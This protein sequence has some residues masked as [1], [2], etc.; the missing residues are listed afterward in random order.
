MFTTILST[1]LFCALFLA[2][3][4]LILNKK[5]KSKVR[6]WVTRKYRKYY[7]KDSE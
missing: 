7:E 3:V 4:T 5:K 2:G 6:E 1:I